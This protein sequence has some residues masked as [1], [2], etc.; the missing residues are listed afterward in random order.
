MNLLERRKLFLERMDFGDYILKDNKWKREKL[1]CPECDGKLLLR[2]SKY[3]LFWGCNNFPDCKVIHGAHP[4]GKPLGVPARQEVRNL[5]HKAHKEL[6][7]Y[8]GKWKKI[9]SEQKEKMYNWIKKHCEKNH[10]A[11]MGSDDISNLFDELERLNKG[12]FIK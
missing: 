6:E 12:E 11:E 10:I 8:F 5:R 3:G 1:D 2:G 7:K 9:S 4:N